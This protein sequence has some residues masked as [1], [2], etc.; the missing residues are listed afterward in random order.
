VSVF[1]AITKATVRVPHRRGRR[2]PAT[3]S[4]SP[5]P[6]GRRLYDIPRT[7]STARS[8]RPSSSP[9]STRWMP[10][11]AA[12]WQPRQGGGTSCEG[13]ESRHRLRRGSSTPTPW[14]SSGTSPST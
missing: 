10:G 3:A 4:G 6:A 2:M 13:E 5:T 14:T 7:T 11:A 8:R 1:K 9:P 12:P